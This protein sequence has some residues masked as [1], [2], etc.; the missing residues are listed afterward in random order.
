MTVMTDVMFGKM[1]LLKQMGFNHAEIGDTL[2]VDRRTIDYWVR[3]QAAPSSPKKKEAARSPKQQQMAARTKKA[4]ELLGRW[5]KVVGRDYTPVRKKEKLRETLVQLYD[6]PAKVARQLKVEFNIDASRSTVRRDL[7][8]KKYK[9]KKV[10]KTVYL[11]K[12]HKEDRLAFARWYLRTKNVPKIIFS[13]EKDFDSN[14]LTN[15]YEWL[16]E[17]TKMTKKRACQM[18]NG[19][20]VTVWGAIADNGFRV[21]SI[22]NKQSITKEVY[23]TQLLAPVVAKLRAKCTEG[24]VFMQDNARPHCGG[25]EW[26]KKRGVKVLSWPWPSLSCDLNPIEQL[27][28]ILDVAVKRRGPFGTE[29]LTRFVEDE[30]AKVS[31]STIDKLVGSFARRLRSVMTAKGEIVKP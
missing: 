9:P 3:K 13:D 24:F 14:G 23:Q 22:V 29:E 27:W 5:K 17:G 18:R 28:R 25:L 31:S 7:K 1:Q 6:S 26:L 20:T 10:R 15:E 2:G 4:F 16:P 30:L 11:T 21:C 8:R 12:K 19:P